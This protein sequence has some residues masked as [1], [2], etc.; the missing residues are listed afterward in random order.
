MVRAGQFGSIYGNVAVFAASLYTH[1][2]LTTRN[3][4]TYQQRYVSVTQRCTTRII[5]IVCP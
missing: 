5:G 4:T 2:I 1:A 3:Y